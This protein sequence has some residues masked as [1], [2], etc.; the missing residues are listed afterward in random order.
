MTPDEEWQGT[1]TAL[2]EVVRWLQATSAT[3]ERQFGMLA[4]DLLSE[5]LREHRPIETTEGPEC[6][7]A[8]CIRIE[9][10][11]FVG[12]LP[13]PCHHFNRTRDRVVALCEWVP[14]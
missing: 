5:S 10:E 9:L 14:L 11:E 12:H 4:V 2:A 3:Q 8:D 6:S 7:S 1:A 13:W